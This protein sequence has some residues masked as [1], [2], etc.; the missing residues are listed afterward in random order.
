MARCRKKIIFKTEDG[1]SYVKDWEML[2]RASDYFN[3]DDDTLDS[4]TC[5]Y[6]HEILE[7]VFE[8][9]ETGILKQIPAHFN[10]FELCS[11]ADRWE[12]T[13]IRECL[14]ASLKSQLRPDNMFDLL[15]QGSN[16][17]TSLDGYITDFIAEQIYT[18]FM[19]GYPFDTTKLCLLE[20]DFIDIIQDKVIELYA[21]KR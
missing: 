2:K 8:H 5:K 18:A 15:L 11:V 6:N 17:S 10:P 3:F 21:D 16:Y 12:Q 7:Y 4:I 1:F 13:A 20:W 9:M 14:L 19:M